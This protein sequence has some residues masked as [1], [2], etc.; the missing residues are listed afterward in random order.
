MWNKKY[1]SLLGLFLISLRRISA[2]TETCTPTYAGSTYTIPN[3]KDGYYLLKNGGSAAVA[4]ATD[5]GGCTNGSKCNLYKCETTSGKT[6]CSADTSVTGYVVYG[7]DEKALLLCTAGACQNVADAEGTYLNAGYDK[8]TKGVILCGDEGCDT[9]TTTDAIYLDATSAIATDPTK[10]TKL[11]TCTGGKCSSEDPF[12]PNIVLDYASK[13][14]NG[15]Y[16][17]L[18]KCVE[19]T[20]T[21][22]KRSGSESSNNSDSGSGSSSG[23]GK[24]TGVSDTC[25]VMEHGA[26][27]TK[28]THYVSDTGDISDNI[29]DQLITCTSDGCFIDETPDEGYYI[30]SDPEDDDMIIQ[31]EKEGE[32]DYDCFQIDSSTFSDDCENPGEIM[33][34][35]SGSEGKASLCISDKKEEAKEI[36]SDNEDEYIFITVDDKTFPGVTTEGKI[37]VKI[38]GDEGSVTKASNNFCT[39]EEIKECKV[40]TGSNCMI[41]TYYL[42]DSTD[43]IISKG[44]GSLFYCAVEN[45][46]CTKIFNIGIYIEDK[47]NIYYCS[48]QD[49]LSC[50]KRKYEDTCD[51]STTGRIIYKDPILSI[52]VNDGVEIELSLSNNGYYVVAGSTGNIF[53]E[54]DNKYSIIKIDG[55]V[56]TLDTKYKNNSKYIY[57]N[58]GN[59]G[60]YKIMDSKES[61]PKKDSIFDK[62]S[63]LELKCTNGECTEPTSPEPASP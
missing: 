31:C 21:R 37:C 3:C 2:A 56:I 28:V 24:S 10:F 30:N 18:I 40:S 35:G 6:T 43:K 7:G 61:C 27:E 55:K 8:G 54:D 32:N 5:L 15:K 51:E 26:T 4:S 57:V 46:A 49:T 53:T 34:T 14:G 48:K 50:E 38:S 42:I 13:K 17:Q 11:I 9:L 47:E 39:G 52:C 59:S 33:I 63:I 25:M 60:K 16:G 22:A 41:E 45:E 23:E 19:G 29:G 20:P 44:T 58:S 12:A 62:D 1:L 36:K